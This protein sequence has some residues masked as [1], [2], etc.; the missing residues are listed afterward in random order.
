MTSHMGASVHSHRYVVTLILAA[1]VG[2]VLFAAVT[3]ATEAPNGINDGELKH[4][5][6]RGQDLVHDHSPPPYNIV[7]HEVPSG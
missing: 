7:K 4:S 6:P 5:L 1:T 2:L 3:S